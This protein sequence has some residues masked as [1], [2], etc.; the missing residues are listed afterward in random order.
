MSYLRFVNDTSA[1][2]IP[3]LKTPLTP[4]LTS[5]LTTHLT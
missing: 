4:P 1:H 3:P 2:H 5:P